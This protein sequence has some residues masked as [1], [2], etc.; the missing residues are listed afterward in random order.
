MTVLVTRKSHFLSQ[1]SI[2]R[3]KKSIDK[4]CVNFITKRKP[5]LR[6]LKA[7]GKD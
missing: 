4:N 1:F 2:V 7:Y 3:K 5:R 6:M